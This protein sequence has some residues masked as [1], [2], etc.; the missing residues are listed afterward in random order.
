MKL[1]GEKVNCKIRYQRRVGAYGIILHKKKLLLTE[2]I[3]TDNSIEIQLPGGGWN[4]NE[5]LIHALYREVL[6]ETGWGIRVLKK[7][8]AFQRFTYMPEYKIWAQK[9]CHIYTCVA[10]MQK[11][12]QLE[13]N[14]R[15]ITMNKKNSLARLVDPGFKYFIENV[16]LTH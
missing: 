10:T 8:G 6:E 13:K 3:T 5:S 12:K 7:E 9:V 4:E 1:F 11:T 14:H 15:F 2:Q 16:K